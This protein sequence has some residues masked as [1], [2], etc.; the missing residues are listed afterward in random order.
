MRTAIEWSVTQL[1]LA[2]A[3]APHAQRH[4]TSKSVRRAPTN[5]SASP[6]NIRRSCHPLPVALPI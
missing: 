4:S 2:G 5:W 6:M 1:V 3:L